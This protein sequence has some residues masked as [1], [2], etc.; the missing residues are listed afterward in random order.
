LSSIARGLLARETRFAPNEGARLVSK[1]LPKISLSVSDRLGFEQLAFVAAAAHHQGARFPLE[2]IGRAEIIPDDADDLPA[3]VT[4]GSSVRYRLNWG[5]RAETRMLAYPEEYA[6]NRSH[7]SVRSPLGAAS[8]GLKPG[9]RMP[10]FTIEGWMHMVEVESVSRFAP[11]VIPL[12]S[13]TRDAFGSDPTT[14]RIRLPR[15]YKEPAM[16]DRQ[17]Q[18]PPITITTNDASRLRLLAKSSMTR[19]PRVAHFLA[20]EI[21]R[22]NVIPGQVTLPGVIRMGS[23]VTYRDEKT[24]RVREV[25]LV[26]PHEA[27]IN[28]NRISVLT[29]VGAALIGLSVGQTIE[30]QTPTREKRSLAVV[31]VSTESSAGGESFDNELASEQNK[32]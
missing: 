6:S 30:F 32:E 23:R 4:M 13:F 24:G 2:E 3:I 12:F 11:N 31:D 1:F 26:Y 18:L 9:S 28:L 20:E 22:A 27:D 19:F 21:D 8:I 10:Y 25:T 17:F 14:I 7:F 5:S 29:P 16:S 15:S